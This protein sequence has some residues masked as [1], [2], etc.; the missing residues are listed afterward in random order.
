M[1]TMEQ[2]RSFG[3]I[4]L[5]RTPIQDFNTTHDG[6]RMGLCAQ[7]NLIWDKMTVDEHLNFIGAI[8]GLSKQEINT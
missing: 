2:P 3:E 1:L 6:N 8:K 5:L 4:Y 7:N